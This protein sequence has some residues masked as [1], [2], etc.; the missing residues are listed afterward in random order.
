MLLP[1][2]FGPIRPED[3]AL[4]QPNE[5]RSTAVKP[6]NASSGPELDSSTRL[7][8]PLNAR[9]AWPFGNGST[10]SVVRIAVGQTM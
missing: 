7:Y 4:G 6:P 3:L 9:S 2:P 5:T 8:A 10:G 1:E